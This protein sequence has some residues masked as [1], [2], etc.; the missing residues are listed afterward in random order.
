MVLRRRRLLSVLKDN[1]IAPTVTSFPM[2]GVGDFIDSPLN[3]SSTDSASIYLPDYIINPHPRSLI[4]QLISCIFYFFVVIEFFNFSFTY[5][6][7]HEWLSFVSY[8]EIRVQIFLPIYEYF[9]Y[10]FNNLFY[11]NFHCS[12]LL[13]FSW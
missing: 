2:L 13:L 6:F 11:E 8:I 10:Q 1:E 9:N 3:F 5:F 12:F 7:F 4:F